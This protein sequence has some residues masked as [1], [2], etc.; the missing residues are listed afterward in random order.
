MGAEKAGSS[1][2][3]SAWTGRSIDGSSLLNGYGGKLCPIHLPRT[4][5]LYNLAGNAGQYDSQL[6][7]GQKAMLA[8]YPD[9]YG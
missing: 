5:R 8:T 2:G 6:T 9:T 4:N 7:T 3:V 1:S